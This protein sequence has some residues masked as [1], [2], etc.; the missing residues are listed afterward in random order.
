MN[1][2]VPSMNCLVPS[3]IGDKPDY[4]NIYQTSENSKSRY[5]FQTGSGSNLL[6]NCIFIYL[7]SPYEIYHFSTCKMNIF[8]DHGRKKKTYRQYR[9]ID[10]QDRRY[11]GFV[12]C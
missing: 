1:C 8:F 3:L 6:P 5:I 2:L 11:G 7:D 12:A 10:N 9:S 4:V